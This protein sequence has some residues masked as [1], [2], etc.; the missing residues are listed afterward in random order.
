[1]CL[2]V[3]VHWL[4]GFWVFVDLKLPSPECF[5]V[6]KLCSPEPGDLTLFYK[7]GAVTRLILMAQ[8]AAGPVGT[9]NKNVIRLE[10]PQVVFIL[11]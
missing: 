5:C 3:L 4:A 2:F 11:I 8:S 9:R 7:K 1:M 10:L 6:D